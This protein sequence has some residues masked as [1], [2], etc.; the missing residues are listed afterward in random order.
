MNYTGFGTK[1][2]FWGKR[3][4]FTR[5]EF[6]SERL[7]YEVMTPSAAVGMLEAIY[8]H[9]GVKYRIDS[10]YVMKPIHFMSIKKNEVV[11]K[12]SI[13]EFIKMMEGGP[14]PSY[15]TSRNISQRVSTILTDVDYIVEF[16]FD[17]ESSD[18]EADNSG[19]YA[20][21]IRRRAA[22]GQCYS[23]PYFGSKEF[24]ANFELW[25]NQ[26]SITTISESRNLG[27]M[28]HSMDYS[29]KDDIK[30]RFFMAELENGVLKV[31]GKKVY[32]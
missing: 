12:G 32:E 2:R 29:N 23:Q 19:K 26:K 30:P 22:K 25:D 8:W 18:K 17:I 28:L 27:L 1:I 24:S 21:I 3:A 11:S 14:V 5:P 20:D 7:S 4:L 16:H 13:N 15:I 9:P 10:I 6:K 31:A